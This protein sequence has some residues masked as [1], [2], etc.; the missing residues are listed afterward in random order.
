MFNSKR[1]EKT[2]SRLSMRITFNSLSLVL[3]VSKILSDQT[4]RVLL[5]PLS[6]RVMLM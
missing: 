5:M 6:K 1:L 4:S 2:S 3:S